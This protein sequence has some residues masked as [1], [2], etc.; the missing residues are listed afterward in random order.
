MPKRTLYSG[1]LVMSPEYGSVIPVA[2]RFGALM[3][4]LSTGGKTV[5]MLPGNVTSCDISSVSNYRL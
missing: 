4:V 2:V 3:T 5:Q 1:H